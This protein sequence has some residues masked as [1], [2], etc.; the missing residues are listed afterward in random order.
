MPSTNL[1][2]EDRIKK[3]EA[4]QKAE[5]HKKILKA[6]DAWEKQYPWRITDWYGE[7]VEKTEQERIERYKNYSDPIER[8][9]LE[10]GWM[11]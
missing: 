4:W 2:Y 6:V 8:Y 3:Y 5:E 9:A 1:H 11:K 7:K 10:N